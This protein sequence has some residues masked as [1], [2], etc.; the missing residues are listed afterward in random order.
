M[1]EGGHDGSSRPAEGSENHL[2]ELDDVPDDPIVDA[3][4]EKRRRADFDAAMAAIDDAT[5][6]DH[7]EKLIAV[8]IDA[9]ELEE[10]LASDLAQ[11]ALAR[12]LGHR[13]RWD[14]RRGDLYPFLKGVLRSLADHYFE[15]AARKHEVYL[16]RLPDGGGGN[17]LESDPEGNIDPYEN[18]GGPADG[19]GGYARNPEQLLVAQET[20]EQDK[21]DFRTVALQFAPDRDAMR[22][23]AAAQKNIRK[24][25]DQAAHAGIAV[26]R[27]YHARRRIG[28]FLR[29]MYE[30]REER[31][32]LERVAVRPTRRA[33]DGGGNGKG[34]GDQGPADAQGADGRALAARGKEKEEP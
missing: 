9:W 7:V 25:R 23:I 16:Q 5:L 31:P 21:A 28:L 29:E 24:A 10:A 14:P 8:A 20:W 2:P 32:R 6:G 26:A 19:S 12:V 30:G 17:D 3:A 22:V 13:R 33:G 18:L 27:I 1:P 4:D 34:Q 15:S 11:E